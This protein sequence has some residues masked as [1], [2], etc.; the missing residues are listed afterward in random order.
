MGQINDHIVLTVDFKEDF[1]EKCKKLY[2]FF[3]KESSLF[4][5]DEGKNHGLPKHI[6]IFENPNNEKSNMFWVNNLSKL[7]YDKK[8]LYPDNIFL[9][10][11]KD[12]D[13]YFADFR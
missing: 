6:F 3:S 4:L 5:K 2:N 8:E 10:S 9:V 7:F 1:S 12:V 11:N 13:W